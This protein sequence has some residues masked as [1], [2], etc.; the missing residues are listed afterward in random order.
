MY[1]VQLLE[2]HSEGIKSIQAKRRD[3]S[4]ESQWRH[5]VNEEGVYK[6]C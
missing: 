1:E 3:L 5:L 4:A 2:L 6:A